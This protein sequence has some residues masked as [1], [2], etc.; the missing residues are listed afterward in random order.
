MRTTA[1]G[2]PRSALAVAFVA[3]LA[4]AGPARADDEPPWTLP[5]DMSA[6]LLEPT[7]R[8]RFHLVTRHRPSDAIGVTTIDA[9]GVIRIDEGIG[10]AFGLPFAVVRLDEATSAPL[11]GGFYFGNVRLGAV[12]GHR[13]RLARGWTSVGPPALELGGGLDAYLPTRPR[14]GRDRAPCR[15]A[16]ARCDTAA[17]ARAMRPL[18]L[19]AHL[20]GTLGGR[21]RGQLGFDISVVSLAAELGVTPA[22]ELGGEGGGWLHLQYAGRLRVVPVPWGE[23]YVELAGASELL[24]PDG[25]ADADAALWLSPGLR[26]HFGEVSLGL[27]VQL[28][29]GDVDGGG[30]AVLIDLGGAAAPKS[31]TERELG[32]PFGF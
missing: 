11:E 12:L 13:W 26:F 30:L 4:L 10:I 22:V 14:F 16:P 1:A 2:A 24:R 8:S 18:D 31:R 15:D 20:P 27:G 6:D 19:G 29:L 17:A 28:A 7:A 25:R 21:L 9:S 23:V 5:L 3:T 32:A